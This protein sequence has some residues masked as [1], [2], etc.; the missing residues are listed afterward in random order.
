VWSRAAAQCSAVQPASGPLVAAASTRA[1]RLSSSR[2]AAA[3]LGFESGLGLGGG[4]GLGLGLSGAARAFRLPAAGRPVQRGLTVLVGRIDGRCEGL[5]E[6]A[7]LLRVR[8]R[9]R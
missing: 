9:V 1:P 7:H 8:V 3:W 2:T 4:A 6:G 5:H